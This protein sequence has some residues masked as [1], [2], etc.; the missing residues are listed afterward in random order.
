[1]VEEKMIN[2]NHIVL[3]GIDG[4]GKSTFL[5]YLKNNG[6]KKSINPYVKNVED[7]FGLYFDNS[8]YDKEVTASI[9]NL[10][11]ETDVDDPEKR[12]KELLELFC[13]DNRIHAD[14]LNELFRAKQSL[15]VSDRYFMSTYAYQ[16]LNIPKEIVMDEI[17]KSGVSLPGLVLYFDID[18]KLSLERVESRGENKEIFE[19][20]ETLTAVKEN[21]MFYFK[22]LELLH[23]PTIIV[24]IDANKSITEVRNAAL[25]AIID[26]LYIG[27]Q[28]MLKSTKYKVL[29]ASSF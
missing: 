2:K 13:L 28:E 14:A 4:C 16:S 8:P 25:R 6:L 17:N 10:L 7:V 21:Y 3:E 20:L 29:N 12:N 1:M 26:Y 5:E 22:K 23:S 9:R 27:K 18:P 15:V 24:L 11:K 19:K